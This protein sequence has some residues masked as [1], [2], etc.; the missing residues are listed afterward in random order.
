MPDRTVF[1][2]KL[3]G[4]YC[5]LVALPMAA[6]KQVTLHM[7]T[8]LVNDPPV[9]YLFGLTTVAAGLAI[10]LNHNVW[11]GGAVPV[12]VTL[13]GWLTMIKGL[14]FLFLPPP[15]AVAISIWGNAYQQY[16]YLDVALAFILGGYLTYAGFNRRHSASRPE[17][18]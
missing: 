6:N 8:A 13:V 14:L 5:I 10:I 17:R 2:S 18:D 16:Y 9:L 3:I 12:V 4:I 7:V 15:A 11:S 1:L